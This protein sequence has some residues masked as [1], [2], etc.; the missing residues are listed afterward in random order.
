MNH[1]NPEPERI[2]A[3]QVRGRLGVG[4]MGEVFLAWDERLQ[5]HVAV[6]RIRHDVQTTAARRQR[7]RQEAR[8]AAS[9]NHPTIV[10][11]YDILE[12]EAE[13]SIVMEYVV[14]RS[15]ADLMAAHEIDAMMALRV[16]QHVAEGL[17]QAHGK[18]LIH[19]DLKAENVMVTLEGQTKILDFGLVKNL[20][21][22]EIDESLTEDGAILGTIR[23]MSPEQAGGAKVDA[24]SDLYS[25]GVLLYEMLTGRSPFQ[26]TALQ[27]HRKILTER[28]PPPRALRPELP[29]EL[30]ALIETL[31]DKEPSRRPQSSSQVAETLERLAALPDIAKLGPAPTSRSPQLPSDAPT[32]SRALG[33]PAAEMPGVVTEPEAG[34]GEIS[35]S[36]GSAPRRRSKTLLISLAAVVLAFAL[37]FLMTLDPATPAT[38]TGAA[39][40]RA[41]ASATHPAGSDER[42]SMWALYQEAWT[43]LARYDRPGHV[44]QAIAGFQRVLASGEMQAAAHAGLARA[45]WRKYL[46]QSLDPIWLEQA[47]EVAQQAVELDGDLAAARI[48]L[49][50]VLIEERQYQDALAEIEGARLLDPDSGEAFLALARL[51]VTRDRPEAAHAA[52]EAALDAGLDR[53]ELHDLRGH[54]YYQKG[55]FHEAL[56]EFA[57]SVERAP[58][59]VLGYRNLSATYFKLGR[60]GDAATELQK[61]LQIQPTANLYT[62]L[63][64]LFFYQGL[65]PQAAAAM[66]KCL[67]FPGGANLYLHWANLGDVYRQIP[68]R[69]E[70]A[71]AA[72]R[73][74]V[75]LL[76]ERLGSGGKLGA[77][78]RSRLALFL[79]KLGDDTAARAELAKLD[80][81]D[82]RLPGV[83]YRAAVTHEVGGR[84]GDAVAALEGALRAGYPSA[85]VRRDP[86]LLELRGDVRYHQMLIKVEDSP[87]V[88][89]PE[90]ESPNPL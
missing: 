83:L 55:Q 57:K 54:L 43:Q 88:E 52:F 38:D 74:A 50:L 5:R 13:D 33:W 20:T 90:D 59:S 23:V 53:Q 51:E 79:A 61:A 30:A 26:G 2:G 8:A 18:G 37:F 56:A 39:G 85:E 45:Y 46:W 58:D 48:S 69:E 78:E 65:Y 87:A 81:A 12:E 60:Y 80:P 47:G 84:R 24:R 36:A 77:K 35:A 71:L 7:L 25:L 16:A 40:D 29:A 64:T 62:N 17:A 11:V 22:E 27:I 42:R 14:G 75:R 31:L 86:E 1:E 66:Q 6:K 73:Q 19:R 67:E 3:Y 32:I 68:G 10:Q 15:L 63:G 89:S 49:A 70:D 44:D 41:L 72:Y 82:W 76:Q 4:G 34:A 28:P 21:R 9:L